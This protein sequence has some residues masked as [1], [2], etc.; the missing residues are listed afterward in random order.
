MASGLRVSLAALLGLALALPVFAHH[1]WSGNFEEDVELSGTVE[2][3]VSLGGP[4]ATMSI[5]SADGQVWSLTLAPGLRTERAGLKAGMIPVGAKVTV[6]GHRNRDPKRFEMK[7]EKVTWN[8][9][10]FE[11]YADRH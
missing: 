8:G 6:V 4:H 10:T 9:R 11:V 7:T 3:T 1:G 2:T 5:R